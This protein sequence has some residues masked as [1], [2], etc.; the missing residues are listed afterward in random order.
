[1]KSI[2]RKIPLSEDVS[3][4]EIANSTD[5]FTGADLQALLYNAQLKAIHQLIPSTNISHSNTSEEIPQQEQNQ[6]TTSST[7]FALDPTISGSV[8]LDSQTSIDIE[9]V[10]QKVIILFPIGN[11]TPNCSLSLLCYS[12]QLSI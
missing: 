7:V 12:H 10:V 6:Y 3:L 2:A 1:M 5:Y 8:R 9:E 11:L 4:S